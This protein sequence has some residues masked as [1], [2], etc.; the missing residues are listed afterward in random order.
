MANKIWIGQ[1]GKA[2]LIYDSRM[3]LFSGSY[4]FLWVAQTRSMR[5]YLKDVIRPKITPIQ[6]KHIFVRNLQ[7][8]R[9]WYKQYGAR[10]QGYNLSQFSQP[11][12][13]YDRSAPD[14]NWRENE[15]IDDNWFISR[16]NTHSDYYFSI[17]FD[18]Y[19]FI[20]STFAQ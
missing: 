6:N 10:W 20:D 7:L 5:K 8:Y 14:M 13:E 1:V 18:D 11:I 3:Q 2:I 4:V 19:V 12:I 16:G 15:Q 9:S 17:D